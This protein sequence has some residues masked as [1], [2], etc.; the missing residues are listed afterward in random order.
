VSRDDDRARLLA[1]RERDGEPTSNRLEDVV[2]RV[3]AGHGLWI[4]SC[5]DGE[6]IVV[7]ATDVTS[8]SLYRLKRR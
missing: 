8:E 3:L 4:W 6:K 5:A 1:R 7:E 2:A